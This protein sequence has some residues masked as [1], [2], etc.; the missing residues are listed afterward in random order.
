MACGT[1]DVKMPF[2][3]EYT[4]RMRRLHDAIQESRAITHTEYG[5]CWVRIMNRLRFRLAYSLPR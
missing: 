5:R 1:W 2:T 3:Y 4:E